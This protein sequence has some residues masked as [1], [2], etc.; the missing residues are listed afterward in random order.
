M[1]EMASNAQV[2][3]E[4][5]LKNIPL[6]TI[7]RFWL[8]IV[9]DGMGLPIY[10]PVIIARGV[11][12]GPI[13]GVTAAVHGDEL[14]GIPVIQRLFKEVDPENLSGTIVGIPVMNAPGYLLKQ[15]YFEDGTDLN[16]IMPGRANGNVSEVY[17]SRW[18]NK[19]LAKF[20]YLLDL[21]T[22]SF[23]RINSYYIRANMDDPFNAQLAL[24]QHAQIILHSPAPDST[25]RGTVNENGGKA[26]TLEVGDPNKF[27][28]GMI[29]SGL[30]GIHNS[31]IYLN[32][33]EGEI[34]YL[35]VDPIICHRSYWIYTEEGG[36]LQVLP[37]VASI[38]RKGEKIAIIRNLFGDIL[39]E[40]YA[41]ENG[42]VIGKS[43]HPVA[44]TGSRILH[45]GIFD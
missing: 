8:H 11:K 18:T 24:L 32:M 27:Q 13:M 7:N 16:R 12:E 21:H 29:R 37:D 39:K 2:I 3:E 38:V 22:A 43:T 20:D 33:T 14:N 31:L 5:N 42:V 28:K 10:L 19:I 30:T 17:A 25:V 45:L 9:D 26:I 6:G 40:Y 34:E 35:K 23:G 15:R 36:I 44:P 41:E 4:I 1:I